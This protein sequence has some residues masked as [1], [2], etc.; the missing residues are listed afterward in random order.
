MEQ[1]CRPQCRSGCKDRIVQRRKP[2]P[3]VEE[4]QRK[5]L[6]RCP[7]RQPHQGRER[8][9]YL[10]PHR[11]HPRHRL[12]LPSGLQRWRN[13]RQQRRS[14][15][16]YRSAERSRK[17][18]IR[19]LAQERRCLVPQRR[20]GIV[21]GFQQRRFRRSNGREIQ[22]HHGYHGRSLRRYICQSTIYVRRHQVCRRQ[23]LHRRI[24]RSYWNKGCETQMGCSFHLTAHGSE[25]LHEVHSRKHQPG[26]PTHRSTRIRQHRLL[27]DFLRTA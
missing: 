15:V 14:E 19:K 24:G 1:L 23:P 27:P 22:C 6:D 18:R 8:Q 11:A 7:R 5:H 17:L 10:P 16:H 26:K 25:G 2:H 21:L 12:C 9:V 13:H 20:R 4:F 3:P